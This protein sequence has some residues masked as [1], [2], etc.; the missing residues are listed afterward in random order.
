MRKGDFSLPHSYSGSARI[1]AMS[2]TVT[3]SGCSLSGNGDAFMSCSSVVIKDKTVIGITGQVFGDYEGM[4]GPTGFTIEDSTVKGRIGSISSGTIKSGNIGLSYAGTASL[5]AIEGGKYTASS[6]DSLKKCLPSGMIFY[7]TKEGEFPVVPVEAVLLTFYETP[8]SSKVVE[9]P[10]DTVL[11]EVPSLSDTKKTFAG[12]TGTEGGTELVDF[13]VKT[14]HEDISFWPVWKV[15][16]SFETGCQAVVSPAVLFLGQTASEP[17]PAPENPGYVL[18]GW[19]LSGE[20]YDFSAP[21]RENITLT[22]KWEKLPATFTVTFDTAGGTEIRPQT[23]TE[24]ETAERPE[25]P[26][27]EGFLFDGWYGDNRFTEAYDFEKPVESDTVIYAKWKKKSQPVPEPVEREAEPL[28]TGTWQNPVLNGRWSQDAS[29]IWHYQTTGNF[30]NTWGYIL[31][32]YAREG[33][34]PADWF[35]FDSLG[36]MLTGWQYINGKWY[37]LNPTKDGT[38]GACQLG[39]VTP[40]GWTVDESGAWIAGIPKK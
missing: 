37:Y 22:A 38:L 27:K 29:G 13:T 34:N 25:D 7:D 16:V 10:K 4:Q 3:C 28:F 35:Y 32:P 19:E 18:T 33:Q 12:W 21:V 5:L 30:R 36:N 8:D 1:A 40:D 24:G 20:P 6:A 9:A 39:G 11:S 17:S 15:T 31:N 26:E 14:F 2:G 23:V